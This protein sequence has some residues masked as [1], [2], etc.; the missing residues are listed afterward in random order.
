MHVGPKI[1]YRT[2]RQA[3]SPMR[4]KRT[5]SIDLG[6]L[7]P[8]F[9]SYAAA[10]GQTVSEAL[11]EVLTRFL[12]CKG[13]PKPSPKKRVFR[14]VRFASDA[15]RQEAREQAQAMNLQLGTALRQ[16]VLEQLVVPIGESKGA[17]TAIAEVSNGTVLTAV[18]VAEPSNT[19]IGL[20][21]T[22]S[23]MDVLT[24]KAK[25]SRYRS[26]QTMLVAIIRSFLLKAPLVDPLAVT[27]LGRDNLELVRI[28]N[29]IRQ[30]VRDVDGGKRLGLLDAAEVIA[31]LQRIDAHTTRVSQLLADA[32]KRWHMKESVDDSN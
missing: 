2:Y 14:D 13:G 16:V 11:E 9:E 21:L 20:R 15:Q 5:L 26:V 23:E 10:K 28:S 27:G 4:P 12:A 17:P 18:G 8:Y 22:A 32:Q 30:L 31:I 1:R 25:A 29:H 7:D 24:S 3:K 6:E 19:R